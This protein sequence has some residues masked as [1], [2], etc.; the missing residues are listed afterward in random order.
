MVQYGLKSSAAQFHECCSSVLSKMG[1]VPSK[2]DPD[3]WIKD[4]GTHYEYVAVYTDGLIIASR[5]LMEIT[6]ALKEISG[7]T[8][9]GVGK[10]E[11][12][13]GGDVDRSGSLEKDG[14]K[15]KLSPKTNVKNMV[16]RIEKEFNVT[17]RN[18]HSPLEGEYHSELDTT[19]LL[20]DDDNT[21]Y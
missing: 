8:L 5:N 18:Y 7:F 21:R 9:K 15:T 4:K 10:P 2:A 12:Y 14:Y 20:D 3:L 16:D 17:L 13:L 6:E 1:F 19:P 11:Y